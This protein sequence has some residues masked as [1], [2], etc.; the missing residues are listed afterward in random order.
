MPNGQQVPGVTSILGILDK[1]ALKQWAW[2]QGKKGV[3]LHRSTE[4]ALD[5]GTLSHF[6]NE[7]WVK[8]EELELDADFRM[9]D[10]EKAHSLSNK[11][12]DYFRS[13]NA[14]LIDSELP[15]ISSCM[16]YGGTIDLVVECDK[17]GIRYQGIDGTV[18]DR[19]IELWDYKTSKNIW[20]EH[21]IQ[22]AAYQ[23]LYFEHKGILATPRIIL[24]SRDGKFKADDIPGEV[25]LLGYSIW[26]NLVHVYYTI[27]ELKGVL[28]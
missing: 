11:F 14:V 24:C 6:I 3:P 9:E 27:K 25:P 26:E 20:F 21:Y 17:D 8:G 12:K 1:P 7:C 2:E 28:A 15:I 23:D 16:S 5:I 13:R 22:I 19:V 10:V 4:S 18:V